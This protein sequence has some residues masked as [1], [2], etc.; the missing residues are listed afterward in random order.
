M[1]LEKALPYT[2]DNNTC[3]EWRENSK[4]LFYDDAAKIIDAF[5]FCKPR[6]KKFDPNKTNWFRDTFLFGEFS[7]FDKEGA[8]FR[9]IGENAGEKGL[10]EPKP[11][12]WN[13]PRPEPP[14]PP[15]VFPDPCPQ[16]CS[17][18]KKTDSKTKK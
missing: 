4:L 2:Y 3:V 1:P 13:P 9:F 12:P 17:S 10:T 15:R 18:D 16:R 7:R 6:D 14:K 5:K 8:T 11:Y